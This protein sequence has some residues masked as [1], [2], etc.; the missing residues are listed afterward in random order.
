MVLCAFSHS[1]LF[2]LLSC[3]F[4]V[5]IRGANSTQGRIQVIVSPPLHGRMIFNGCF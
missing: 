5:A 2:A 3:A 4:A 1:C